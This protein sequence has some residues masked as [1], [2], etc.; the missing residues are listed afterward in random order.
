MLK[1]QKT[2]PDLKV[3]R[4]NKEDIYGAKGFTPDYSATG[5]AAKM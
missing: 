4:K 3:L 5:L 2:K 1:R